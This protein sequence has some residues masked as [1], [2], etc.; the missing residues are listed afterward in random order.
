VTAATLGLRATIGGSWRAL[1][2]ALVAASALAQGEKQL[3]VPGGLFQVAGRPAFLIAPKSEGSGRTKPWVWYAPTLPNLPG[4]AE[5]WMFERFLH[6]GIAVAGIDVG[7][8]YG[9]PDGRAL[10][11]A[12]YREMT[13]TRGFAPQPVLL[14]RSRGGL[15]TLSWAA[16]N[17]A[18]VAAFAGIYPVCNLASYPGLPKAAGAFRLT[19]EELGR[20]LVK[21]NPLD[22]LAPLAAARVPLF[23]IH[24]DGDKI[25]SLEANSGE[26]ARRY[27]ALGGTLQLIVPPGQ[28]HNMWP[29]F[30]ECEELVAF[31]IRHAGRE[32]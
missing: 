23:A 25:V 1:V 31:V 30:F 29:G 18:K 24:G 4:D 11:S 19:A 20:E 28:G 16:E 17:P 10:F 7:E 6:A 26:M 5:R 21:H 9:S 22:R 15:M 3:P 8:S 2:L 13:E 14:G 27:R 32:M 12:L